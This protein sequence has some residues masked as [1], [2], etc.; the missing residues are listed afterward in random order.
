L[1]G[2]AYD[3]QR[4]HACRRLSETVTV[5]GETPVVDVQTS[6]KRQVVLSSAMISA[7]PAARG[8]GNLLA[9]VPG[10]RQRWMSA[11]R[12]DELLPRAAGAAASTI[13]RRHERRISIQRRRVAGGC[14]SGI[15]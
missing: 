9:T 4:R 12:L 15:Q 3:D 1:T 6:T 11:R 13:R 14:P 2:R 7:I 5:T 10:I 8:Y